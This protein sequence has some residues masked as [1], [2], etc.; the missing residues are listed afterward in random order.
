MLTKFLEFQVSQI[1]YSF[2]FENNMHCNLRSEGGGGGCTLSKSAT[3]YMTFY[4][5]FYLS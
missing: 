5:R 3:A 2:S 1:I 4:I